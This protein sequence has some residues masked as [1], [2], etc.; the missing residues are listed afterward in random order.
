MSVHVEMRA[1]VMS[2]GPVET[3]KVMLPMR[4][5]DLDLHD[6]HKVLIFESYQRTEATL[7]EE[8]V[9]Q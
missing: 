5:L 9:A 7:K 6:Y 3:E 4:T 8:K 1:T 2:S